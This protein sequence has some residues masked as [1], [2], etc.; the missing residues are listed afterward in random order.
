MLIKI[1]WKCYE[2]G[3]EVYALKKT[4]T[5]IMGFTYPIAIKD[6][7]YLPHWTYHSDRNRKPK[8]HHRSR[9]GKV[10]DFMTLEKPYL[11]RFEEFEG[12]VWSVPGL[13]APFN[14][15]HAINVEG[16]PEE[17]QRE[18]IF[19]IKKTEIDWTHYLHILLVERSE[20][21]LLSR[22]ILNQISQGY[23]VISSETV[24]DGKEP[25]ILIVFSKNKN[26]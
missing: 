16:H 5:K 6:H 3:K 11:K 7:K 15:L 10:L 8:M 24:D 25:N 22:E 21:P 2:I 20:Y 1:Y 17:A 23:D 12:V 18:I 13:G 9:S 19:S 4:T 26:D 14:F